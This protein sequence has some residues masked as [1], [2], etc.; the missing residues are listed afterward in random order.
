MSG[1]FKAVGKIAGLFALIPS[2]IQPIAAAVS[3]VAN[4]GATLTAKKPPRY[5]G[6][7]SDIQIGADMPSPMMLGE[8]YS[9]GNM[10]HQVG[11]GPTVND[12]PNTWLFMATVYSAG[13]PIES[14][15]T[16]YADFQPLT[17]SAPG[18]DG[19]RAATGYFSSILH[20]YPQLGLKPE[21][22]ALKTPAHWTTPATPPDWGTAYKLSGKAAVGWSL[23][24]DSKNGKYASG[25]PQLGIKGKGVKRYDMRLDDTFSGGEGDHR[26]ADPRTDK[27]GYDAAVSTWEWT[28]NPGIHGIN[29]ALGTWE[30][31]IS[32]TDS[33]YRLTFG[34]GIPLDGIEIEDFVELANVCEA[35]GWKCNGVIW[36]PGDKWSNLKRIL[37]AGGA[38]PCFKG[39]KLGLK[40][41]APRIALDTITRDDIKEGSISVAG[42]Q[43]WRDRINTVIPKC[44]SPTHKWQPQQSTIELAVSD[45]V[46]E[47]GERK[48]QEVAF[49]LVTDF[50]QAAQL[51]AY[52]LYD[53]REAG[54]I[55]LPLGPRMRTYKG[56]DLLTLSDDLVE[57]FG[58]AEANVVVVRREVDP[59]SMTWNF[60]LM[61]ETA[62]KHTAALA[63]NGAAP[64]AITIPTTEFLD[65]VINGPRLAGFKASGLAA[66]ANGSGGATV[67]FQLPTS[68]GWT[69]VEIWTSDTD[70]FGTAAQASPA[71]SITGGLGEGISEGVT[72]LPPGTNYFWVVTFDADGQVSRTDSVSTSIGATFDSDDATMDGTALTFDNEA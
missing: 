15:D 21:T 22:S 50:D 55:V 40:I 62:A 72:G 19:V 51:A 63:A 43:P 5:T 35:N 14:I 65:S 37:E 58:L 41:S 66:V 18:V 67:T 32:D 64:D 17:L 49:D 42:G 29:Y 52:R 47:D 71:V 3:V 24:W 13:G 12:V 7:V 26:W 16:F 59:V 44:I 39:G 54:P 31:D 33:E 10:V 28:D 2:P 61:T 36:E 48:P 34:I 46:E 9:G 70:D 20:L 25:T 6:S 60:T 53:G 57:E 4:I 8:T 11:Y 23:K 68:A 30:R 69:Y 56:G 1:V 38:E 45:W 27:A